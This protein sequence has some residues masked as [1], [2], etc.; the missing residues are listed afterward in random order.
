MSDIKQ[1][2]E[3][4]Q[5]IAERYN[6]KP[7]F[8]KV[9]VGKDGPDGIYELRIDVPALKSFLG[10]VGKALESESGEMRDLV[11]AFL[12]LVNHIQENPGQVISE[13]WIN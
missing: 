2:I 12:G 6:L 1:A 13:H 3:F 10:A 9:L 8:P 5:E 4:T 11:A 7:P